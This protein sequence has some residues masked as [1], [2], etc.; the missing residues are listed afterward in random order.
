MSDLTMMDDDYAARE[1]LCIASVDVKREFDE[2]S[3]AVEYAAMMVRKV[4]DTASYNLSEGYGTTDKERATF[5]ARV[6][7]AREE[8]DRLV[9]AYN[10]L[11]QE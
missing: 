4:A 3:D 8:L 1:A 9:A 5:L 11:P 6:A 10:D 2:T 7:E